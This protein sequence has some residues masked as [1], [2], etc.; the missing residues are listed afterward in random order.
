MQ[1][2]LLTAIETFYD[3][4]DGGFDHGRALAAFS[5]ATGNPGLLVGEVKLFRHQI[6]VLGYHNIPDEAVVALQR[7]NQAAGSHSMMENY[8]LIPEL[9]P[10][11]RRSFISDEDHYKSASYLQSTAPWGL[12]SEGVIILNKGLIGG[13]ICSFVKHPGQEEVDHQ[14]LSIMSLLSGHLWRA[15]R[16]QRRMSKLEKSLIASSNV[17]DLIDFGL[18]LYDRSDGLTFV[19][20]SARRI[21]SAGDGLELRK[22][23]LAIGDQD[24]QREFDR[25][26]DALKFDTVPIA[27]RAG[28]IV[29]VPRH[30]GKGYYNVLLV[31]MRGGG[32]AEKSDINL[33]VFVFDPSAKTTTAIKVFISSYGLTRTEATLAQEL[34]QGVSLDE[35]SAKRGIT[36]NTAKWHLQAIFEKTETSRQPELVSLLL[37]SV[38][39][40]S[41]KN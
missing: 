29:R 25:L 22:N 32:N 26:L 39:G 20:Q 9:V 4:V 11:L 23:S 5:Q 18:L 31:P 27:E 15:M 2:S 35:F 28:G 41:L 21:F 40:V 16:L 6:A 37:R 7:Q 10:V 19:N 24:A 13:N 14:T 34:A 8:A 3:C 36:R 30:F 17:L 38:A 1:S 33:A 12:H